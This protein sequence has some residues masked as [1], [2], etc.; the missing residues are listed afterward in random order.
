MS[1][2]H[3][4]LCVCVCIEQ[5]VF[6]CVTNDKRGARGVCFLCAKCVN[7]VRIPSSTPTAPLSLGP[8][9]LHIFNTSNGKVIRDGAG[10]KHHCEVLGLAYYLLLLGTMSN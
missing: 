6:T 2:C 10:L 1:L 7:F 8:A 4:L 3:V 9:V 5:L